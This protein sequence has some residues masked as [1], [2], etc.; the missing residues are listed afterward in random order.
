MP[1]FTVTGPGLHVKFPLSEVRTIQITM[2]TDVVTD[3]P[4]GT[5]GGVMLL[6]EKIEVVNRLK[7]D[8]VHETIKNYTTEYDNTW[9][10]DRIHHEINQFCSAHTLQEVYITK[11]DMLDESLIKSLQTSCDLWAPG[12]E[13]IAVRVTK[14]KIPKSIKDNFEEMEAQKTQLLIATQ[15]QH[16]VLQE[17]RTVASQAIIEARKALEVSVIN[18]NKIIAKKESEKKLAEIEDQI[19]LTRERAK[20]D[21]EYYAAEKEA[22]AN[23]KKLSDQLLELTRQE[24]LTKNSKLIMGSK[25]PKS[26]FADPKS[27]NP[28]FS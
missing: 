7:P 21:A 22:E 15:K 9:I 3:I 13:I 20:A 27:I 25:I 4:C 2:Q 16:V 5:S 8:L 24:A 17:A 1:K 6:F 10:Y 18:M 11:F 14:P 26:L 23:E 12:I 28:D 19:H